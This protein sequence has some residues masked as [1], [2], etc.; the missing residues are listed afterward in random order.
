MPAFMTP[1]WA[2]AV[3]D[4]VN[5]GPDPDYRA[6][7]LEE[8]WSW[9]D[10]ARQGFEGSV[11]L[12]VRAGHDPEALQDRALLLRFSGGT[13]TE[14]AI[15]APDAARDATFVLAGDRDAYVDLAAGYEA[16]KVVMY[17]RLLLEQG[18][19]LAFFNR[20]YFFVEMLA[21]IGTVP[22]EF[23]EPALT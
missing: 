19:L 12:A 16:G 20:V 11:A 22:T 21:V 2:E 8:Y 1:E 9:I 17:R 4:A 23:P 13:C 15:V 10:N 5:R 3:R 18:H 7:K 6:G 14:A